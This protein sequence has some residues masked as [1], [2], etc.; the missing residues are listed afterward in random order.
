MKTPFPHRPPSVT[1]R[2]FL[3][4]A[5][6]GL[7]ACASLTWL[8]L[9]GLEALDRDN[10]AHRSFTGRSVADPQPLYAMP[11]PYPGR[12]IEIQSRGAVRNGRTI[13]AAAVKRMMERGMRELTG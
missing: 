11:G 7:A 4:G 8:G 6:T 1:R 3:L 9:K 2:G 13:N 10:P 12:V 5:S